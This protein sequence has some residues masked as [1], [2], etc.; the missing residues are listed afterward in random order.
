MK[1]Y[2]I[3]KKVVEDIVLL[4]VARSEDVKIADR[5][6]IFGFLKLNPIIVHYTNNGV[7][8]SIYVKT[9]FSKNALVVC[10]TISKDI[11]LQIEKKLN[12]KV[13]DIFINLKGVY[14]P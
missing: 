11:K 4:T 8:I 1:F 3:D 7:S 14:E 10:E 9:I 5:G 2:K 6:K 12:L 13:K